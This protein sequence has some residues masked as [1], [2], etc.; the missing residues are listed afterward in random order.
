MAPDIVIVRVNPM[1][2]RDLPRTARE[3]LNRVNEISFNSSLLRELR[4]IGFITQL[5]DRGLV[6]E[7][8]AQTHAGPRHRR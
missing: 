5:I 7:R 1:R 3:I 6:V 2:R 8:R 4:A